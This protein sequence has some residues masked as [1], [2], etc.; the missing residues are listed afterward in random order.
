MSNIC[1]RPLVL[2]LIGIGFALAVIFAAPRPLYAHGSMEDPV[3]RVYGCFLE[4][5]ERPLTAACQ[6]AVAAAGTQQ[7]Y[8]WTGV[9]QLANGHHQALVPDGKLCSGGKASHSG[10]D[11]ARDDWPSQTIALDSNGN[12]EFVFLA[13]APHATAYFDFYVTK[14]GYDPTQPLTWGDLEATP[15]CHITSVTLADGR[16]RMSCPLPAN[17][18]GKQVIYNIW[19]RSDSAEAFYTCMDVTFGTSAATP[20]AT[21]TPTPLGTPPNATPTPKPTTPTPNVSCQVAYKVTS[22]WADGFNA[23][24][25]ITNNGQT[26]IDGWTLTWSFPGTQAIAALWNGNSSQS[27]SGVMVTNESWNG[28]LAAQGGT[29]SIGFEARGSAA[30]SQ[31][32]TFVLNGQLCGGGSPSTVTT[33]PTPA[34]PTTTGTPTPV[35]TTTATP[36][37]VSPPGGGNREVVAYFAQWG[38]YERNYHVKNIVTSGA[39]AKITAINYAFGNIVDGACVMTTQAGVMDAYADYQ[40]IYSAAES[41][42]GQ[43][44][45]WDQPLRGNFNQLRKLKAMYPNLKLMISLGG[46]TW[47]AGFHEAAK[48]AASRQQVAASCIDL[49]IRGNLPLADNAGGAGVAA[50]LFDGID[51]DWEYPGAPGVGNPYGPEDSHNFTLLLGE[52]RDQLDAIDPNLR[53]T[54]ATAAGVDTY[55]L[56]ELDQIHPLLNYINLM[57]YDFHGAWENVTGLHAALYPSAAAPYSHPASTYAVDSAVQ[58]Y[59]SAGVPSTKLVLG[60][61]F[62]GRGWMGVT[63]LNHGLWQPAGA[64]APGTWEAGIEDYKVIKRLTYPVYRDETAG[65]VWKFNG[66]TFWSYDDPQT[67]AVKMAYVKAQELGGVMLWSLEGDTADGELVAAVHQG[68]AEAN[69]PTDTPFAFFLPL[70]TR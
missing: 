58:G 67:L 21:T 49:Y 23:D 53:L 70:V 55:S 16:Y 63:N 57:A 31:P 69:V 47:S 15:F 28:T 13:T 62:Y 27:G 20:T 8:D 35:A 18:Q 48:T 30:N 39:A 41:V 26:A 59:L 56:L 2:T 50:G 5:P 45:A 33:T 51:I 4:G 14:D 24:L 36:T 66:T 7:F 60:V 68:L 64:G 43:A 34:T 52:F 11:L 22:S 32:A 38:I 6:A 1:L 9:N 40:K 46:W 44:D 25:L 12:Y 61:P 3:S 29:A 54:V 10:L 19:Q 37:V 42:D 65:A 17:K